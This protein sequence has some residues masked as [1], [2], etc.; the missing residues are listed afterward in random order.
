[1]RRSHAA[2]SIGQYLPL[3]A[4]GEVLAYI[5]H[6]GGERMLIALNLSAHP[7]TLR[8]ESRGL[9]GRAV[10]STHLDREDELI[11]TALGLRAN[12]GLIVA[13]VAS[14]NPPPP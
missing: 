1:L 5:R 13:I 4:S 10:L 9:Q 2:L 6:A 7:C 12:E 3:S 14:A 11:S 8:L